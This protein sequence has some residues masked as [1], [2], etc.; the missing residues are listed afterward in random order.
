MDR[1]ISQQHVLVDG[2][3]YAPYDREIGIHDAFLQI[4]QQVPANEAVR[5]LSESLTYEQLDN[6]SNRCARYLQSLGLSQGSR[7]G[8]LLGR[9]PRLVCWHLSVLKLGGVCVPLE[10]NAPV[11]RIG[12]LVRSADIQLVLCGP[13]V[14]DGW[15]TL[16]CTVLDSSTAIEAAA[17]LDAS[18]LHTKVCG[19]DLAYILF[20]SGSTGS[21]KGVMIP[22][23]GVVRLVRDQSYFPAG[24]QE[25][26]LMMSSPG[27]DAINFDI[28]AP[29]LNGGCCA[30]YEDEFVSFNQL[31]YTIRELGVTN[32][33]VTTG[34]FNRIL[35]TLPEVF[36][37]L[38]YVIVGGEALSPRHME[39]AL[40]MFP[41]VKFANGYGPTECSTFAI[42]WILS[43]PARWRE[44]SVPLGVPIS[45]TTCIVVDSALCPVPDGTTGELLIGGDGVA[46][47]YL[48]DPTL[49]LEKF[50]TVPGKH[51]DSAVFYRTG[52]SA[53][54]E[55]D[56]MFR[57][58]G[59][60]DE[61]LKLNGFRVEPAE[62]ESV[63]CRA[64]GVRSAAVAIHQ[65]PSGARGLIAGV[66]VDQQL[67]TDDIQS[68]R[69]WLSNLL[70]DRMIPT[71]FVRLDALPLNTNGK[72]DR[73]AISRIFDSNASPTSLDGSTTDRQ[74][75]SVDMCELLVSA[76]REILR[77]PLLGRDADFFAEGGDSLLAAELETRLEKLTSRRIPGGTLHRW[78][79][80]LALS[81]LLASGTDTSGDHEQ[82][83]EYRPVVWMPGLLGY[84]RIP[85]QLALAL[86]PSYRVFDRLHFDIGMSHR[87]SLTIESIAEQLSVQISAIRSSEPLILAGYSFGGYLAYEAARQLT[88]Q[89]HAVEHVILWDALPETDSSRRSPVEIVRFCL[90]R[91]LQRESYADGRWFRDR[92]S[93]LVNVL[94]SFTDRDCVELPKLTESSVPAEVERLAHDIV[95]RYRPLP[96]SG[97]V[98]LLTCTQDEGSIR[99]KAVPAEDRWKS[100][101]RPPDLK[102]VQIPCRH[103]EVFST[104]FLNRFANETVDAIRSTSGTR[105]TFDNTSVHSRSIPAF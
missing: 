36:E 17:Y 101:I 8:L 82:P 104:P 56:G 69:E 78:R 3:I 16:E 20:T 68:L 14:V 71:R 44:R 49:T 65:F 57:Y 100:A 63:L 52:D 75:T 76:W 105:V 61:Q 37:S 27:F 18:D 51:G 43:E 25:C 98:T 45:H 83:F 31:R 67:S 86:E 87:S 50:V 84:G 33:M 54:R 66:V 9:S 89:G 79:T 96:Y 22:H 2:K 102:I 12:G 41:N 74:P 30:V 24:P 6:E 85:D 48:N 23:R 5:S 46:L 11:E 39:R 53:V 62:I 81:Q 10:L 64:P 94:A 60:N 13:E 77:S 97:R 21:P 1:T 35:D 29:L 103:L 32:T 19:A 93:S 38:R 80:P 91:L 99:F 34:L 42:S 59:R 47:G 90:A 15:Q 26:T 40:E 28:W 7:V 88:A 73:R 70:P 58:V 95:R 4:A 72:V 55:V 92:F